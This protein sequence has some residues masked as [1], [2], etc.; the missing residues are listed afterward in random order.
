[1]S[2]NDSGIMD[3]SENPQKQYEI[4][5]ADIEMAEV[6]YQHLMANKR[7]KEKRL[8]IVDPMPT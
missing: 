6:E 4:S 7:P 2:A 8:E 1:L 3:N 5:D